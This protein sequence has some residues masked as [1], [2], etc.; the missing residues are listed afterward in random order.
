MLTPSNSIDKPTNTSPGTAHS[1]TTCRAHGG[2]AAHPRRA[3][4]NWATY[5]NGSGM[6]GQCTAGTHLD[7]P[8]PRKFGRPPPRLT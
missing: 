7:P 6:A 8:P 1:T 3:V 5:R 2:N 4:W